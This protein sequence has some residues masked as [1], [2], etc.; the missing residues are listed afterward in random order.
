MIELLL[1]IIFKVYK[2]YIINFKTKEMNIPQNTVVIP[3]DE[4]NRLRDFEQMIRTAFVCRKPSTIFPGMVTAISTVGYVSLTKEAFEN[5]LFN[6]N[7]SLQKELRDRI[8]Q[9]MDMR[10]KHGEEIELLHAQLDD[11]HRRIHEMKCKHPLTPVSQDVST[12]SSRFKR[13]FNF[14]H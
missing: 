4:Y 10:H 7:K 9:S 11:A 2:H 8:Q 3:L 1:Y 12:K 13:L 14:I 5:E 6:A